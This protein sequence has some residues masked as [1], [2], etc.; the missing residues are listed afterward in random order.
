MVIASK[1]DKHKVVRQ[2]NEF[3]EMEK[4]KSNNGIR[5]TD[6]KNMENGEK[7]E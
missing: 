5:A 6:Q 2:W 1:L 4:I 3:E 7:K